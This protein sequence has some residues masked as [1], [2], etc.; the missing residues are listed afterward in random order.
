MKW[1]PFSHATWQYLSRHLILAFIYCYYKSTQNQR[2]GTIFCKYIGSSLFCMVNIV[3][4][5]YVGICRLLATR[6]SKLS[7]FNLQFSIFLD[8]E[9]QFS[10]WRGSA[11]IQCCRTSSC[12][13]WIKLY[14]FTIV[15]FANY[16]ITN[17]YFQE[18]ILPD[19]Q[20]APRQTQS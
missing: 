17:L 15:C 1:F 11:F 12:W 10:P 16:N 19:K 5:N 14:S 2:P 4:P 20:E 18:Q 9:H 13:S 6:G 3:F 7:V 8:T